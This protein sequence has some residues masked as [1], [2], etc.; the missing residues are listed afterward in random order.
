[1]PDEE[2]SS[3]EGTAPETDPWAEDEELS[4]DDTSRSNS[5]GNRQHV[6]IPEEKT[7]KISPEMAD[8]PSNNT[9]FSKKQDANYNTSDGMPTAATAAGDW[10]AIS[11][12]SEIAPRNFRGSGTYGVY[13]TSTQRFKVSGEYLAQNLDFHFS[14]GHHKK[15]VSQIAFGAEYQYLLDNDRFK[16]IELGTAYSHAFRSHHNLSGSNG[17]LSFLGTTARLWNCAFL[18]AAAEYDW[19]EFDRKHHHDKSS[20]G[21]GGSVDFVQQFGKEFSLNLEAQF[22]EPFN[23]YQGLVNWNHRFCG[24]NLDIGVF[25]NLTNG[26]DGVRDIRTVGLQLG[27]TFGPRAKNCGRCVEMSSSGRNCYA[28]QYCDVSQWVAKPAVYVPRRSRDRR[29]QERSL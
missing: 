15:W 7:V 22:R 20:N 8:R 23:S 1:M 10:G 12:Y 18:S 28:R 11:A 21:F 14:S 4:E 5:Y 24:F 3:E 17:S 26:H 9:F 19:V 13:F 29:S 2:E 27:M 16:S 25:G 6:L